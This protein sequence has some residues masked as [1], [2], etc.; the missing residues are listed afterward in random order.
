[1]NLQPDVKY[2]FSI[3]SYMTSLITTFNLIDTD[4]YSLDFHKLKYSEFKFGI[5]ELLE[6]YDVVLVYS[7]YASTIINHFGYSVVNI[8]KTDMDALKTILKARKVSPYIAIPVNKFERID[9]NFLEKICNVNLY[10]IHFSTNE[11]FFQNANEAYK[12]GVRVFIG[13]GLAESLSKKIKDITYFPIYPEK[14]NIEKAI[15]Q[16]LSVAKAKRE[17]VIKFEQLLQI[18]RVSR[19]GIVLL[20]DKYNPVYFNKAAEFLLKKY[21]K[22]IEASIKLL[23]IDKKLENVNH[24]TDYILNFNNNQ[25]LVNAIP[26]N[27]RHNNLGTVCFF[28]DISKIHAESGRL[29]K[30][31]VQQYGF[32]ARKYIDD[33]CGE[34]ASISRL[35][36]KIE[37]YARHNLP[38]LIHGETG[39]GKEL[40][41]SALHNAGNRRN[42]PFVA[43]NCAALPESLLES[44]LF[45]YEEGAFTDSRRGGKPGYFEMAHT[46]TLFLDEI[47]EL[48]HA[49]Q[50]RLL[51][52]LE[53]N[54]IIRVG[55]NSVISVDIRIISASHQSLPQLIQENKFRA[56]LFYRLSG[57]RLEIPPLRE[58][59]DDIYLILNDLFKKYKKD[60]ECISENI[61]NLIK[62]YSWPGNIRE[63]KSV[64]ESYLILIENKKIDEQIFFDVFFERSEEPMTL[65]QSTPMHKKENNS[66][67]NMS[68]DIKEKTINDA[69]IKYSGDK[70]QVAEAL[71]I[72]YTT[73]WRFAKK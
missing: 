63:L 60:K 14:Y 5:K 71:G 17:D 22:S 34:S 50:A 73:V 47:A 39:T 10:S 29:R 48:S 57:F 59:F 42:G 23:E 49:A 40:V 67:K 69:L 28:Q 70:K 15:E 72:S 65:K 1:M 44:E 36:N 25:L 6:K 9:V 20:D 61:L 56:D 35:K 16:A 64:V 18:F 37:I 7:G 2:K 30:I 31:Q 43:V 3:V 8:P 38:I 41:A 46:G 45:G 33:I 19:E 12:N 13:G 55:G 11:E 53:N 54:E 68:K 27:F 52:V 58:R 32:I 62:S 26:I 4:E 66:F 51:R 21:N 24:I